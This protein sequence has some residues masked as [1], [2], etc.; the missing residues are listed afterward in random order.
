VLAATDAPR[1]EDVFNL[2]KPADALN[3]VDAHAFLT[4]IAL[5]VANGVLVGREGVVNVAANLFVVGVDDDTADGVD[6]LVV[7]A[8]LGHDG[9]FA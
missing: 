5:D 1:D 4:C 6:D 3:L 2:V 9:S 7:L 8:K